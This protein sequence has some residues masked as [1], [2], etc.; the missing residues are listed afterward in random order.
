MQGLGAR[1]E[2]RVDE[3]ADGGDEGGAR[4]GGVVGGEGRGRVSALMLVGGGGG[5]G[6][7]WWGH[8]GGGGGGSLVLGLVV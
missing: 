8:G 3:V 5:R 7:G 1:G 6:G 2:L 4:L